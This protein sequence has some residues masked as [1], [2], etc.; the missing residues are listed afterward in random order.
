MKLLNADD[1]ARALEALIVNRPSDPV[2]NHFDGG[3]RTC[4][5][6]IAALPAAQPNLAEGL[7]E[8]KSGPADPRPLPTANE[9]R[10]IMR[11]PEDD[12]R[13]AYAKANPLGGPASMFWMMAER[14]EAGEPYDEVLRDYGV[15]IT[16]QDP[17]K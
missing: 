13:E 2:A 4:M 1:I 9:V 3:V 5:A 15:S 16:A 12:A 8:S 11:L 17:E 10:G 6:A 7:N 14:I